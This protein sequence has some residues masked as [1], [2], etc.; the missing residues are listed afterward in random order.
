MR[1]ASVAEAVQ[2]VRPRYMSANAHE[3]IFLPKA[4]ALLNPLLAAV[5]L[6]LLAYRLSL[7]RGHDPDFPRNLSKTLTVD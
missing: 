4:D 6:Q 2:A 1:R 5:P 7:A 3:L